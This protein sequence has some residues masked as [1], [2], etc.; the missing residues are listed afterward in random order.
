MNREITHEFMNFMDEFVS[1]NSAYKYDFEQ[2]NTTGS[3]GI[4]IIYVNH[5]QRDVYYAFITTDKIRTY[6]IFNGNR[7]EMSSDFIRNLSKDAHGKKMKDSFTFWST[8]IVTE[9][10]KFYNILKR[11]FDIYK[12]ENPEVLD[13]IQILP[14]DSCGIFQCKYQI[15]FRNSSFE[16]LKNEN[17]F[18]ITN[19]QEEF[20]FE[21]P[22]VIIDTLTKM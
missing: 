8:R 11:Q 2:N 3:V 9:R 6:F 20:S 4:V 13:E 21:D 19:D 15:R 10:Q 1:S 16:I 22:I 5:G 7:C 12:L 17:L 18:T 14:C